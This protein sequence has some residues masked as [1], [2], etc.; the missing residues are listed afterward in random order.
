MI[1]IAQSLLVSQPSVFAAESYP[2]LGKATTKILTRSGPALLTYD[3]LSSRSLFRG[4]YLEWQIYLRQLCEVDQTPAWGHR[5]SISTLAPQ[6]FISPESAL[7]VTGLF[8]DLYLC[9]VACQTT[10][11][12]KDALWHLQNR[13]GVEFPTNTNYGCHPNYEQIR[14]KAIRSHELITQLETL[15]F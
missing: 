5:L 3:I 6:G 15:V 7:R 9:S 10:M 12:D 13:C 1:E 2:N 11:P 14:D 8:G 4:S